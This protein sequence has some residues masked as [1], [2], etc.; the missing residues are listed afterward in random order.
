MRERWPWS[1][2][3]R[4]PRY[5]FDA[6]LVGMLVA[7]GL[8]ALFLA[9]P[10]DLRA[11][12]I[13][14]ALCLLQTLPL[15][16]RRRWPVAVLFCVAA[17]FVARMA[18]GTPGGIAGLGLLVALYSVGAYAAPVRRLVVGAIGVAELVV[19][20]GAFLVRGGPL[21]LIVPGIAFTAAWLV[22]DY[23]RARRAV[24]A[25]LEE[26][27]AR[28]ERDR[29]EDK[30][31]AADEE[32]ARIARELHDVIAHHVSAITVQAGAARVAQ[33]Q[34]PAAA[35]RTLATIE[36]TARHALVELSRLLGVI[37]KEDGASLPRAP[38]PGLGDVEQMVAQ[39][40][41][42]G[43]DVNV[44]IRGRRPQPLP[45]A[46]DLSAYRIVQE[47]VT[48]AMKHAP[49]A[50]VQVAIRYSGEQV[51]LRVTD[52]G[53]GGRPAAPER[54]GGH[55]IVG[56]QE[57]VALFGGELEIGPRPDGGFSVAARLPLTGSTT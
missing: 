46:L 21:D 6:I 45:T 16:L 47:A 44:S 35:A 19:A 10:A 11:A 28:A 41:E 9:R 30:R 56:M 23:I 36:T 1:L 17:A 34:D 55:G 57:R 29:E 51:E 22:G 4:V 2:L 42:A 52:D 3:E 49:N 32:R 25:D 33:A 27:A 31:R 7:I 8:A 48:N 40:R 24:M 54:A 38:Q 18:T 26:R 15:L 20:V 37:R 53:R 43:I 12:A 50:H 14:V 39:A 5:V 13:G